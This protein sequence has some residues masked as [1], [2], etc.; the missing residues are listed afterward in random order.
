MILIKLHYQ[1]A[2]EC[3]RLDK[4]SFDRDWATL[5]AHHLGLAT[6]RAIAPLNTLAPQTRFMRPKIWV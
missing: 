2:R 1:K 4:E 5:E 3:H 6:D